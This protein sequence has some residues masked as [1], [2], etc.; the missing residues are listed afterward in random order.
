MHCI[1]K[2]NTLRL[3]IYENFMQETIFIVVL[4]SKIYESY[5]ILSRN[6]SFAK[7]NKNK[8]KRERKTSLLV[9]TPLV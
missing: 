1:K 4:F 8:E 5:S 7:P 6:Y 9:I 2:Y 3:N